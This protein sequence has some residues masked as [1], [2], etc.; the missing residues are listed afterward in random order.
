MNKSNKNKESWFSAQLREK[1]KIIDKKKSK[2]RQAKPVDFWCIIESS[3]GECDSDNDQ[4][5]K[6]DT[7]PM[8][9]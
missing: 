9:K 1:S 2:S 3:P 7:S 5:V 8:T 6:R 4:E